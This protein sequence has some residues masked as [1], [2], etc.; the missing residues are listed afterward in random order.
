MPAMPPSGESPRGVQPHLE[1]VTTCY[2][3]SLATLPAALR[4]R[5]RNRRPEVPRCRRR[6]Q[7]STAQHAQAV[8]RLRAAIQHGIQ[9]PPDG[10]GIPT[11][12]P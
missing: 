5:K 6:L 8:R 9:E 7:S 12:T 3:R 2:R 4:L 10:D 1:G 11:V